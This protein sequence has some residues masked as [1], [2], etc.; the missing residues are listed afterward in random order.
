MLDRWLCYYGFMFPIFLEEKLIRNA[1]NF[2][3]LIPFQYNDEKKE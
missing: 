3:I 1:F 2:I